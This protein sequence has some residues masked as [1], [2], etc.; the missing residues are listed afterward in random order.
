[1]FRTNPTSQSPEQNLLT[2]ARQYADHLLQQL[3]AEQA[4]HNYAVIEELYQQRQGVLNLIQLWQK[5]Q[6]D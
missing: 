3:M 1:M 2:L 5:I 4:A 6:T